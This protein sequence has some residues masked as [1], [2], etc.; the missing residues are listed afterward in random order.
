VP[1]LSRRFDHKAQFPVNHEALLGKVRAQ[2]P[3]RHEIRRFQ[4]ARPKERLIP[5]EALRLDVSGHELGFRLPPR[6]RTRRVASPSRE[7]H[8][9]ARILRDLLGARRRMRRS[10]GIALRRDHPLSTEAAICPGFLSKAV[11]MPGW[12]RSLR[13]VSPLVARAPGTGSHGTT[14]AAGLRGALRQAAEE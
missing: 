10:R 8:A 13:L 12:H 14:D 3:N 11:T 6:R 5:A 7:A 9:S 4:W 1:R 2:T